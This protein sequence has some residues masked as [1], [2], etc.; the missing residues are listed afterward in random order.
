MYIVNTDQGYISS[1]EL[2]NKLRFSFDKHDAWIYTD[3]EIHNF[4]IKDLYT[5]YCCESV[6]IEQL[7]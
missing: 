2:H 3:E 4:N 6:E 5:Y 7:F 1:G